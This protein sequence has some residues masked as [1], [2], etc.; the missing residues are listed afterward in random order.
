VTKCMEQH[1]RQ[2]RGWGN[3]MPG[4]GEN[5][6]SEHRLVVSGRQETGWEGCARESGACALRPR[7]AVR[8]GGASKRPERQPWYALLAFWRHD[9]AVCGRDLLSP[10]LDPPAQQASA[11]HAA[12]EGH[13][14]DAVLLDQAVAL[15]AGMGGM[16][17]D[18]A[19]TGWSAERCRGW[20]SRNLGPCGAADSGECTRESGCWLQSCKGLRRSQK[21]WQG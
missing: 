20:R 5:A 12:V 4:T 11:H 15:L 21:H 7:H 10:A 8:R 1:C 6:G 14:L 9:E 19:A 2:A 17:G 3:R 16:S 13:S 18:G